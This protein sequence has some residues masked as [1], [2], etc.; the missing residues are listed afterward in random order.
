[1]LSIACLERVPGNAH[2][3]GKRLQEELAAS[4]P[5]PSTIVRTTQFH[6]F[7][8]QVAGWTMRDG[9]ATVPPLLVQPVAVSDVADALAQAAL[10]PPQGRARDLAGPDPQDLVDMARRT[11]AARG[12]AIRLVPSWDGFISMAGEVLL[13]GPDA[14]IAPTSFEDWLAAQTGGEPD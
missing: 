13:P 3:E 9:V 10:G 2:Y 7:A 5:V 14:R 8:A 11:F 12:Q 1:V 6:D 4:G